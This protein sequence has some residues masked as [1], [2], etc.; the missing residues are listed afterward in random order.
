MNDWIK[1][2]EVLVGSAIVGGVFLAVSLAISPRACRMVARRI[3]KHERALIAFYDSYGE[4]ERAER[5]AR[6]LARTP[7][8]EPG[9]KQWRTVRERSVLD[10]MFSP[11]SLI[12]TEE[13]DA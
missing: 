10:G 11:P 7:T 6:K 8:S 5:M 13:R 2:F 4:D 1:L 9:P 3:Q 12:V